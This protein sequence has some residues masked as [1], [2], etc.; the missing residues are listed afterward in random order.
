MELIASIISKPFELNNENE[1]NMIKTALLYA[2]QVEICNPMIHPLLNGFSL[3][4]SEEITNNEVTFL[5][6][7]LK[8]ESFC[9]SEY[10]KPLFPEYDQ[11]REV[12]LQLLGSS[13]ENNLSH[14]EIYMAQGLIQSCYS[15]FNNSNQYKISQ[16]EN[17][18]ILSTID[19]FG[20]SDIS[21]WIEIVN[22]PEKFKAKNN[23]I[24]SKYFD[25][26][27]IVLSEPHRLPLI[28]HEF[29]NSEENRLIPN[30]QK[31][32]D[33][34]QKI[35]FMLPTIQTADLDEILDIRKEFGVSLRN[36]RREVMLIAE[37]IS[38]IPFTTDYDEEVL[39]EFRKKIEPKCEEIKER[40]KANNYLRRVF[41]NVTNNTIEKTG[42]SIAVAVG[43]GQVNVPFIGSFLGSVAI[44]TFLQAAKEVYKENKE[45]KKQSM[46]FSFYNIKI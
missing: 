21:N 18:G 15:R 41:D 45:I 26:I 39:S 37:R 27:S 3:N 23:E 12:L 22:S 28:D 44:E 32:I 20:E 7:L 43:L 30:R 35:L 31:E 8:N 9:P 34:A 33:I 2:D 36:F 4:Q 42:T 19:I 11:I 29:Y 10:I 6:L 1:M 40:I 24:Q 5:E 38:S 13:G 46:Y 16:L 17:Q 25:Y 14:D